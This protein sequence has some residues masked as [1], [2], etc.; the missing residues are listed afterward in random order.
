MSGYKPLALPNES[1]SVQQG[2]KLRWNQARTKENADFY[3]TGYAGRSI[4]ELLDLFNSVGIRSVIDIRFSPTSLYRPEYGKANLQQILVEHNIK[5]YHQPKLGVPRDV[6][7]IAITDKT[8]AGIWN[9]YDKYVVSDYVGRN[10][11]YFFNSAE[12]P[13]VFLCAEIDPMTCHRHRLSLAL[14]RKGLRSYDL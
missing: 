13:I 1:T 7:V 2:N 14:E 6:R 11:N 4:T 9:W 12:H 8:R 10:L 3:T 5:Y